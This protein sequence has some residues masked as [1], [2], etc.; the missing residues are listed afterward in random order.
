MTSQYDYFREPSEF[1]LRQ[2]QDEAA[3]RLA[4]IGTDADKTAA[5][6][7]PSGRS[8]SGASESLQRDLEQIVESHSGE[9]LSLLHSIHDEP[10]IAFQERRSAAK[11]ADL[12]AGNGFTP[13]IGV[14]SL[15]TAIRA[16][17]TTANFDPAKH[18]T[19]GILAEYDALIGLGH[20]CGHNVIA[21]AGTGAAIALRQLLATA[22]DAPEGRLVFLGTPAEEGRSGKEYMA[23]AGAFDDLDAAIMLHPSGNDVASQVW[24][25]RRLLSV[26]F[27]GRSAH[28]SAQ[29]YQG[30]NA[31]DAAS[32]AYQ[33]I[34]LMRQQMIPVDRVHAVIVEGGKRA[35]IIPDEARLDLYARSEF[36]ET[37]LDL[38]ERLEHIF[39]GAAMMTETTV[40]LN[41]DDDPPSLPVRAN[42]VLTERWVLGERRRGRNPLPAGTLPDTQPASTDFG[43]VSYRVPGIHPMLK[44]APADVALHTEAFVQAAESPL[45]EAG[46][47]DGAYGLAATALDFLADDELAA[48]VK[49]EFEAAGGRV[50]VENFFTK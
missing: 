21:T 7:Q 16:E 3:A 43:N 27:T 39:R 38:S 45:A 1:Y 15:D 11:I 14:H 46:G 2:M 36:P 35:S 44:V 25:G 4:M 42:S 40:T 22:K 6:K 49:A 29:P 37:L 34:G 18:R 5:A 24:L 19:I 32:L 31:L 20:G 48:A 28:A 23:R 33:A 30:R 12:L 10:E 17:Y 9:L 8:Y 41:W 13:K 26:T 50:D 47:I